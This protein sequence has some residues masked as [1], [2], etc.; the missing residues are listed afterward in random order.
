MCVLF[1]E[2]VL[3]HTLA[4]LPPTSL[5]SLCLSFLCLSS[6]YTH[7]LGLS[8]APVIIRHAVVQNLMLGE[9]AVGIPAT[10][11]GTRTHN[12]NTT[13]AETHTH[14]F[15]HTYNKNTCVSKHTHTHA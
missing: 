8:L 15:I 4:S 10:H 2:C 6:L 5:S 12:T 9:E 1:L 14:T 11:R 7:S 13:H 3:S